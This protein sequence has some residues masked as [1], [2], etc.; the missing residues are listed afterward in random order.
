MQL[1]CDALR[2]LPL[3]DGRQHRA[4]RGWWRWR[5]SDQGIFSYPMAVEDVDFHTAFSTVLL[6]TCRPKRSDD[7]RVRPQVIV[8]L[9]HAHHVFHDLPV[10]LIWL[11]HAAFLLEP[12]Q[13]V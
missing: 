13:V 10:D 12:R 7:T 8:S 5:R 4:S 11:K 3:H 1:S 9:Q 2:T 6:F